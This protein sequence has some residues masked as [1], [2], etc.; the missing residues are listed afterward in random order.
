MKSDTQNATITLDDVPENQWHAVMSE[1]LDV[2]Y[3]QTAIYGEGGSER[4]SH[5]L[6]ERN[7]EAVGERD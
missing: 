7:G 5:L 1:F 3:E 6:I 2:H 4:S